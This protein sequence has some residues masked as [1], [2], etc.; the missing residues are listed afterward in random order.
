MAERAVDIRRRSGS[1]KSEIGCRSVIEGRSRDDPTYDVAGPFFDGFR[2]VET[3]LYKANSC[4]RP[5][6]SGVRRL[7]EG[8]LR[9]E[10]ALYKANS[11]DRPS[12]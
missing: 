9:V 2:Q 12:T 4:D 5:T 3:A 8:F 6:S 7:V 10:T 11:R 1:S